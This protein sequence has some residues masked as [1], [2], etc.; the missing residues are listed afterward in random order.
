MKYQIG[1][2]FQRIN[3]KYVETIT[4]Y[5]ITTNMEGDTVKVRY[6]ATHEF[7]GQTVTDIDIVPVTIA[8]GL[9]KHGEK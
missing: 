3:K 6:V 9:D 2:K 5:H 8:R 7:C 1:L 4:D